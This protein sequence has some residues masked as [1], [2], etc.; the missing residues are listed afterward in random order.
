MPAP[1]DLLRACRARGLTF[2]VAGGRLRWWAPAG[3]VTTDKLRALLAAQERDLI[4]LLERERDPRGSETHDMTTKKEPEV[5]PPTTPMAGLPPAIQ[6]MLAKLATGLAS[7]ADAGKRRAKEIVAAAER[8]AIAYEQKVAA[9][10]AARMTGLAADTSAADDAA[11]ALLEKVNE[12]P[13]LQP[14]RPRLVEVPSAPP[15]AHEA[16]STTEPNDW[17]RLRIA[18]ARLPLVVVGGKTSTSTLA[19]IRSRVGHDVEWLT[20][21]KGQRGRGFNKASQ[22]IKAESYGAVL[23]LGSALEPWQVLHL[24]ETAKS[25]GVPSATAGD[26]TPDQIARALTALDASLAA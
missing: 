25:C 4:N 11:L 21:E 7:S 26:Y 1:P 14:R 2:Q 10:F 12:L 6:D 24:R 19:W 23:V 22:R 8:Y 20:V 9:E 18:T 3:Q 15:A 16:G 13:E 17:N 5:P